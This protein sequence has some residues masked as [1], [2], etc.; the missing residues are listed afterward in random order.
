MAAGEVGAG[1]LQVEVLVKSTERLLE[2]LGESFP[3][4]PARG[5]PR[6]KPESPRGSGP[7]RG[8]PQ[9]TRAASSS[10]ARTV[11]SK[12]CSVAQPRHQRSVSPSWFSSQA[13]SSEIGAAQRAVAVEIDPGV[14]QGA[15]GD[16]DHDR[17]DRGRSRAG[18]RRGRAPRGVR[19][20]PSIRSRSARRRRATDAPPLRQRQPVAER[21]RAGQQWPEIGPQIATAGSMPTRRRGRRFPPAA[22]S[23]SGTRHDRS[24]T[25][26]DSSGTMM[27]LLRACAVRVIRAVE[28]LR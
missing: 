9:R 22:G 14:S 6:Q 11:S 16:V 18:R 19:R 28:S 7:D 1:E 8:V 27:D 17:H 2:V 21:Q 10:A 26:N 12:S 15:L 3:A 25:R 20:A 13:T 5:P 4:E 24:G 23:D